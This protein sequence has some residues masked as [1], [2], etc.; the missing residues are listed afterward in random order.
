MKREK[1][2]RKDCNNFAL[3]GKMCKSCYEE[4]RHISNK[5]NMSKS[6]AMLLT[7]YRR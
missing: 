6:T 3:C 4:I 7:A 5:Y 1:C 2:I